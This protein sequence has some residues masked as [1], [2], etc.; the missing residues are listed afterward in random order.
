M[1][2]ITL[3]VAAVTIISLL[4]AA[5]TWGSTARQGST[6]R[7][8][9]L[10]PTLH[11]QLH[12]APVRHKPLSDARAAALVTP[13]PEVRPAN[14]PY[15]DYVPSRAQLR[16]FLTARDRTGR[17]PTRRNPWYRYV[18]GRDGMAH[19]STDMLIQ[20]AA[21]KWGIPE[22][23][24]RA[25]AQ[26]ETWWN[27]NDPGD[28]ENVPARWVPQYPAQVRINRTRVFESMGIMQ[29]RWKPNQSAGTGS[30]PLRWRSTAFN[31]DYA[32]ATV[33]F[34]FDGYCRCGRGYKA[35]DAWASIGGY[36]Q[37]LPWN[38]KKAQAYI[39]RI[40]LRLRIR[41]WTSPWF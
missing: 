27:Q 40:K 31:L 1:K 4:G 5:M 8:A 35:G 21:H 41:L 2:K 23:T 34:Y 11:P 3:T 12:W 29:I 6:A 33:R 26:Q 32:G 15:N 24:M 7:H 19:P 25:V 36:N 9:P 22:D 38:S 17:N 28:P 37:P 10:T 13:E 16:K 18:D 20:W 39:G 30:E 14:A